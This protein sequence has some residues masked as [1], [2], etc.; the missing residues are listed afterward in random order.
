[1]GSPVLLRVGAAIIG[2]IVIGFAL[3]PAPARAAL[4]AERVAC[5]QPID[6]SLRVAN[7]L[8]CTGDGLIVTQNNI[9]LDLGGHRIEGDGSDTG[10]DLFG[11]LGVT[12]RNGVVSN[13]QSGISLSFADD[14]TVRDLL[15]RGTTG[16][17]IV[18]SNSNG[19]RILRNTILSPGSQGITF[20]DSSTGNEIS[21]NTVIGS[22]LSGIVLLD[23]SG[24]PTDPGNAIVE[25]TLIANPDRA[26]SLFD[27]SNNAVRRNAV[28]GNGIGI[29]VSESDGNTVAGN[30]LRG[31]TSFGINL[32]VGSD[33][34]I[35]RG[36]TSDANNDGIVLNG[37]SN[38][39]V[40]ENVARGNDFSG[41]F[42]NPTSA[43]N[44]VRRNNV[45]GNGT[46]GVNVANA[47]NT[48]RGNVAA[49]NGYFNGVEDDSGLGISAPGASGGGNTSSGSDD[50]DEC[51]PVSLCSSITPGTFVDLVQCGETVSG[52]FRL[53]NNLS[54]AG[55]GIT[56][57]GDDSSLDLRFHKVDGDGGV[58]D[59]GVTST[60]LDVT[61]KN[62]VIQSFEN[63]IRLVSV[64]RNR[65]AGTIVLSS[66]NGIYLNLFG[67]HKVL[68]NLLSSN[69]NGIKVENSSSNA[70][71]GNTAT[72]SSSD[73]IALTGVV[74]ETT[75]EKNRSLA[76]AFDG[77]D[78][79]DITGGGV[80]A[81]E[82][83]TIGNSFNGFHL[84]G[85]GDHR[86]V[87]NKSIGN[88]V[89]GFHLESTI[90]NR[91]RENTADAN[92]LTGIM[93]SDADQITIS[94]N[95]ARGNHERGIWV[96]AGS[97][98]VD[99]LSN[100][101]SEN[102]LHGIESA[103]N[104]DVI[105]NNRAHRNGFL[106]DNTVSGNNVGLGITAP[107]GTPG[108]G[109][110]ARGNDDPAECVPASLCA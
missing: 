72:K 3:P 36:N 45:K 76:N 11:R 2:G 60:G 95:S 17:G 94:G 81:K 39:I 55:D 49:N 74:R 48:V 78:L 7:N 62:G 47:T 90:V 6:H 27:S 91:L 92:A 71:R 63:G 106:N 21:G 34:N 104:D 22:V 101:A 30:V 10:I 1:M 77:I 67:T 61:I 26:V 25:N 23:S 56:V 32:V 66:S 83:R 109:N 12:V 51:D 42:V 69:G 96:L 58:G 20:S 15:V 4:P 93:L 75:I 52:A 44:T 14:S 105:A 88:G 100:T 54:C 37:S 57:S 13:F 103:D 29:H 70:I 9:T 59:Y 84:E 41:I 65:V 53:A 31:Q 24:T 110:V 73:G 102:G 46:F 89:F 43:T 68:N 40:E 64:F 99:V 85:G 87:R 28:R 107:P 16:F 98:P 19:N 8:L 5:G 97:D 82:N 38:N 79:T 18:G 108:S 80:I 35:V 86:L 33:A 50:P